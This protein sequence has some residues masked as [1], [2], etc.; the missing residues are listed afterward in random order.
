MKLYDLYMFILSTKL[1]AIPFR[2]HDMR[3]SL[4][5]W[6]QTVF[7]LV[8]MSDYPLTR[9][10]MRLFAFMPFTEIVLLYMPLHKNITTKNDS[11]N[12]N[13][14]IRLSPNANHDIR[15]SPNVN[16]DIRLSPNIN[17]N[18]RRFLCTYVITQECPPP[19]PASFIARD[20]RTGQRTAREI[21]D[22]KSW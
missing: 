8:M 3:L 1:E 22:N 9:H 15:L 13:Y 4:Q 20:L 14:D 16:H 2:S 12:I 6:Y 17:H 10:Y 7:T 18:A 19:F 5:E 21:T 11:S